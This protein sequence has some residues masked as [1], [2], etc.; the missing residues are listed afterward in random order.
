MCTFEWLLLR[1]RSLPLFIRSSIYSPLIPS[2]SATDSVHREAI[3]QS[4]IMRDSD[5]SV[6]LLRVAVNEMSPLAFRHS[7]V[8]PFSVG[9]LEAALLL[10]YERMN[11]GLYFSPS[12]YVFD[13]QNTH[14]LCRW[15]QTIYSNDS[16]TDPAWRDI[17]AMEAAGHLLYRRGHRQ[18]LLLL[19]YCCYWPDTTQSGKYRF[20]GRTMKK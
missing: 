16:M 1:L 7:R 18:Q 8:Q 14:R 12:R 9:H 13:I 15:P 11:G 20:S 10:A 2:L 19:H 17:C 3:G 6:I 5:L 4:T